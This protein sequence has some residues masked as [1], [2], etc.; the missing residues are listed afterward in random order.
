MLVNARLPYFSIDGLFPLQFMR[1]GDL[2]RYSLGIDSFL[3]R[4][5]VTLSNR[6]RTR[7]NQTSIITIILSKRWQ[8]ADVVGKRFF[9]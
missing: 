5:R 3:D 4:W 2:D 7:L 6:D 8:H 1:P 9:S